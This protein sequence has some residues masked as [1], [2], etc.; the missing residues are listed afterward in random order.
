MPNRVKHGRSGF[1]LVFTGCS[2]TSAAPGQPH[3]GG[4][5]RHVT[6]S[7]RRVKTIDVHAHCLIPEAYALMGRKIEDHQFPGLDEVGPKRIAAMDKQGVDVKTLS[8]NPF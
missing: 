3:A 2:A 8:I 4:Q 6:V 7:G 1:P 5:R